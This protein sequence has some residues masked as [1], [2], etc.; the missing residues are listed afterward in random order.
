MRYLCQ[1]RPSLPARAL[2]EDREDKHLRKFRDHPAFKPVKVVTPFKQYETFVVMN[3]DNQEVLW[4]EKKYEE[5][6][7]MASAM[8][9]TLEIDTVL[10]HVTLDY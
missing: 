9:Q 3:D 4:S 5:A 2:A 8:A 7:A 6:D 10:I 1:R